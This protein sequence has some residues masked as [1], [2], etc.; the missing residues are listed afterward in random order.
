M[1]S[2]N[3]NIFRVTGHLR[4]EFPVNSPHKGQWR[5]ALMFPLICGWI[6]GWVNNREAGDL[7]RQCSHYDVIVMRSWH[8]KGSRRVF[9]LSK[10]ITHWFFM[11]PHAC[12]VWYTSLVR[13]CF[14]RNIDVNRKIIVW[15]ALVFEFQWILAFQVYA[16]TTLLRIW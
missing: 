7:R 11:I 15:A 8:E 5:E 2:S 16:E 6:N 12:V 14:S 1:T 9:A 3:G 13:W 4:G 10:S